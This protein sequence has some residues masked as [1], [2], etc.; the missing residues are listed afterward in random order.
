MSNIVEQSLSE[1]INFNKDIKQTGK[2]K[3]DGNENQ[4]RT[5]DIQKYFEAKNVMIAKPRCYPE[6]ALEK[7][8]R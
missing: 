2:Y 8:V 1:I 5:V 3:K 6:I 4:L 7:E